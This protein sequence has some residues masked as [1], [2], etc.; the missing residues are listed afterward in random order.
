MGG[1]YGDEPRAKASIGMRAAFM[2]IQELFSKDH[3]VVG[4][5]PTDKWDAIRILLTQLIE[6]GAVPKEREEELHAA[7]VERERSMST[8]MERGLAIPHAAVDG[9]DGLQAVMGTVASEAG[10]EFQSIDGE[11]TRV[12]ILLLIPREQKLLHIRTLADIARG[13]GREGVL[14]AL[15]RAENADHAWAALAGEE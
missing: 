13:L 15:L 2:E 9:L 11:P 6:R 1:R 3:L 8:G 14:P 7:L 12:V 10:L 5:E 4:V